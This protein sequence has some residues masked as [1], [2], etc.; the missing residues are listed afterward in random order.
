MGRNEVI[1]LEDY[2]VSPALRPSRSDHALTVSKGATK[3]SFLLYYHRTLSCVVPSFYIHLSSLQSAPLPLVMP[4]L[5]P[6]VTIINITKRTS[7]LCLSQ[8]SSSPLSS[9]HNL[10]HLFSFFIILPLFILLRS[11][12]FIKLLPHQHGV[13]PPC[14]CH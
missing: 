4:R 14:Y 9:H 13:L 3:F 10:C 8:I 12:G 1:F 7:L 6:P 5:S 11:I 2:H